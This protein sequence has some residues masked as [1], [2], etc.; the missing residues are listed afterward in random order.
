MQYTKC[1]K[2]FKQ[3]ISKVDKLDGDKLVVVP[4]D[5]KN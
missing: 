1:I 5:L 2:W 3:F 4:I